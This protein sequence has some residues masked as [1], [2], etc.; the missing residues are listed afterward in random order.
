[1][2][3]LV[4]VG[5][6]SLWLS[7][8][9]SERLQTARDLRMRVSG[10][11]SSVAVAAS[12]LGTPSRWLSKLPNGPLGR[13]VVSEL[14]AHGVGTGVV[15]SD[16]G[17]QG[18]LFHESAP[19]PRESVSITDRTET[20]AATMTPG[21]LRMDLVQQGEVV[22][23]G[24]RTM[25]LSETAAATAEAVLRA[26]AGE[27]GLAAFDLD[28]HPAVWDPETARE[29]IVPVLDAVDVLFASEDDIRAVLDRSGQARE[30]SHAVAADHDFGMVVVT[31]NEHGAL[32]YHDGVVHDQDNIETEATDVS[33]QHAALIGGFLSELIREGDPDAALAHG[34]ATAAL[35]R[36]IPGP[37]AT[38]NRPEVRRLIDDRG[39]GGR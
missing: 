26:G 33:G 19:G 5:D 35:A 21:E 31:R 4:T 11:E 18:L 17:R 38:I 2:V 34:V 6:A 30:L 37:L 8:T 16:E 22:F 24:G 23:V 20:A 29:T 39:E 12:Q 25:A 10:T 32:V 14:H 3:D 27:G 1:M 13:R 15:W 28:Y 9:G 7:P 36:T